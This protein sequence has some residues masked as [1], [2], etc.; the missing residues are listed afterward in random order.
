MSNNEMSS[1]RAARQGSREPWTGGKSLIRYARRSPA[2]GVAE[3]ARGQPQLTSVARE[4]SHVDRRDF[5]GAALL[6][7]LIA[8]VWC[9]AYGRT[10]VQAWPTPIWCRGDALFLLSYLK[11]AHERGIVAPAGEVAGEAILSQ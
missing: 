11:A 2:A 6:V 1:A 9:V 7:L 4:R 10:S 8:A 5:A 3:A